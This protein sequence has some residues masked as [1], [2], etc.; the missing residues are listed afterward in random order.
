[1][2]LHSTPWLVRQAGGPRRFRLYCFPHA[3]G[4]A[5]NYRHWQSRFSSAIEVCA[6]QLPGRGQRMAETPFSDL[7]SLVKALAPIIAHQSHLPFAFFGHSMG[8][9]IAY[10]LARYCQLHDLPQ[11]KA[12]FVSGT[13]A[14]QH[15]PP[16]ENIHKMN[17][18]EMTVKLATFNGTPPE[19]LQ[20]KELMALVLPMMRAD[21]TMVENY[22]YIPAP[23]L[24]MPI[25]VL[26]G[27][28]DPRTTPEQADGWAKETSN[29]CRVQWF[30]GDHFFINHETDA[31]IDC[32]TADLHEW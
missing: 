26:A 12:L 28:E 15:R 14:P 3:G 11:P 30:E 31:V 27:R 6:V 2:T 25:T 4:S 8:A 7:S 17:D 21:F 24:T 16:S 29:I 18:E 1:M 10:E 19:I 5:Q 23:I 22:H 20:H 9:L 32:I 13:A